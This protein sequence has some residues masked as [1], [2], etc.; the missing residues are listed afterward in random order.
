MIGPIK[1]PIMKVNN[2]NSWGRMKKLVMFYRIPPESGTESHQNPW[3]MITRIHETWWDQLVI[4]HGMYIAGEELF[5]IHG[6]HR[7]RGVAFPQRSGHHAWSGPGDFTGSCLEIDRRIETHIYT[8]GI[9]SWLYPMYIY[10]Y[11]KT[12]TN[13]SKHIGVNI[14]IKREHRYRYDHR[15]TAEYKNTYR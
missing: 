14:D 12:S 6:L 2:R 4:Q 9:Y 10:I 7:I 1:L 5:Q 8:S 3:D 15:H 13:T 11:V